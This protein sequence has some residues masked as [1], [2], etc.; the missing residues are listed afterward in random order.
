[1]NLQQTI[2]IQAW[3]NPDT[4]KE[5]GT[6]CGKPYQETRKLE[7]KGAGFT[8]SLIHH[9]SPKDG[10]ALSIH[11]K[12]EKIFDGKINAGQISAYIKDHMDKL[13]SDP[14]MHIGGWYDSEHGKTYLDLSIVENDKNKAM[15]LA[16]KHHQL[17]VFDLKNKK[18]IPTPKKKITAE[19][20][21]EKSRK[22]FW[23]KYDSNPDEIAKALLDKI[24]K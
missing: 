15:A 1:M 9:S 18:V 19:K 22:R 6:K 23:F 13:K 10:Y 24:Y 5:H 20:D 21:P 17:A 2:A 3:C 12:Y 4:A 14:R 11:K 7:K 8:H 16:Q